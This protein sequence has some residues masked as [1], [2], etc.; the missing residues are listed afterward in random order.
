M[1]QVKDIHAANACKVTPAKFSGSK[2]IVPLHM[3]RNVSATS[4]SKSW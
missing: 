1:V 4:F 3:R 2:E